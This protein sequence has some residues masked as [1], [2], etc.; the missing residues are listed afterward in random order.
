MPAAEAHTGPS[1]QALF[2]S[3]TATCVRW[4]SV[5]HRHYNQPTLTV[6]YSAPLQR[7]EPFCRVGLHPAF[8]SYVAAFDTR[9]YPN[10]TNP[11]DTIS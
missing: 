3:C 6:G 11:C 9:I 5:L 2:I 8:G 4:S 7:D 10:L 1:A